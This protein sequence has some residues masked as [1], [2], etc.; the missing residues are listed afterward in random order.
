[1]SPLRV[2]A[3]GYA[4]ATTD[5]GRAV[6]RSEDLRVGDAI[7]VRLASGHIDAEVTGIAPADPAGSQHE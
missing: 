3:R 4:I 5:D 6:R 1:M 2:L 7:H